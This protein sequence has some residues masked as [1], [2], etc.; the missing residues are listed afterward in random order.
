MCVTELVVTL[1]EFILSLHKAP[2]VGSII[3]FI[4]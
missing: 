1:T 2:D 3:T 4:F